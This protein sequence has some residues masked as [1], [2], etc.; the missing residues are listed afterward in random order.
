[1]LRLDLPAIRA[2]LTDYFAQDL[3]DA[4]SAPSPGSVEFVIADRSGAVSAADRDRLATMP[5][6]V[7]VHHVDASHWL[8]I[9]APQTVIDLFVEHL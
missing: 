5:P 1:M 3:W 8:H 7:H 9:D 6:H 2:M 4:V